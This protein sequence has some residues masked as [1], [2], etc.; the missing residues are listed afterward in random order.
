M[1]KL[2]Q[3]IICTIKFIPINHKKWNSLRH[4]K[5]MPKHNLY[6][7]ISY[8]IILREGANIHR[9]LLVVVYDHIVFRHRTF[10]VNSIQHQKGRKS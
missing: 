10:C 9:L 6:D 5:I 4:A 2:C 7:Q 8:L 3:T 1:Q